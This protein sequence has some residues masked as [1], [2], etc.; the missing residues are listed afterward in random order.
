VLAAASITWLGYGL[1]TANPTVYLTHALIL[2]TS[3]LIAIRAARN[4][5][6]D[7]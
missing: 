4:R 7:A 6:Q 3:M 1:L 2:P 5:D